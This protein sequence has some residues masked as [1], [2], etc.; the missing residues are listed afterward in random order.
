MNCLKKVTFYLTVTLLAFGLVALAGRAPRTVQAG[1]LPPRVTPTPQPGNEGKHDKDGPPT[2]A[3]IELAAP[4]T[5]A[6]AWAVVQW[7][8]SGGGWHDVEGWR[9]LASTSSRW[10]V[11]PKDFGTGPFRWLVTQGPG[12]PP[13]ETSA[14]FTLPGGAGQSVWVTMP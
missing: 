11:H 7:Q 4:D 9:G 6:G 13:V 3:Y 12:G 5:L 8:D 14:P 1:G 10:W 2:G